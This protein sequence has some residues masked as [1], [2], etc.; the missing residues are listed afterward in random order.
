MNGTS[1]KQTH[2]TDWWD[3]DGTL[4]FD[5]LTI[6]PQTRVVSKAGTEMHL[7]AVEFDLLLFLASHPGQVFT[8]EELMHKVWD[9]STP[10][11][12]STVTVHVRRLREKVEGSPKRPTFIRTVWGIGYKFEA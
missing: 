6:S 7:T 8:R 1:R 5:G 10:V 3:G 9:Y 4:R 12:C 11:D 2:E